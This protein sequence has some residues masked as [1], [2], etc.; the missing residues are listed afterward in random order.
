M[1]TVK[2]PLGK[3]GYPSHEWNDG[4][5]DRIY[6]NGWIDRKNYELYPECKECP[7]HVDKA[8]GDLEKW[9]KGDDNVRHTEN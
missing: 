3:R 2:C 8:L 4:E 9:R 5:K 1:A 6:Y 7:D